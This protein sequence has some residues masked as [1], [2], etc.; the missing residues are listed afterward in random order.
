MCIISG[1]DRSIAERVSKVEDTDLSML[2]AEMQTFMEE[3]DKTIQN[4]A[5]GAARSSRLL[6]CAKNSEDLQ[7]ANPTR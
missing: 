1:K 7:Q 4:S 5:E 6:K 3:F 2:S